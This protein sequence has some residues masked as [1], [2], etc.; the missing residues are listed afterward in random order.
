MRNHLRLASMLLLV[1]AFPCI[2]AAQISEDVVL[3]ISAE[4]D[5]LNLR[6]ST[7]VR[8][9]IEN[10][11]RKPLLLRGVSL[12][13]ER[14]T[15][16]WEGETAHLTCI[17]GDCF[18]A[19][20]PFAG[21]RTIKPADSLIVEVDLAQLHWQDLTSSIYD[22]SEPKNLHSQITQ[23]RYK[24]FIE[25]H[26]AAKNSTKSDPRVETTRSNVLPVIRKFGL[27]LQ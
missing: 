8:A 25:H 18:F 17:R 19:R 12:M 2:S 5:S 24:L 4:K 26:V 10:R 23:G 16:T 14:E 11:S 22:F 6:E 3:T 21:R 27:I 7:K 13:L 1:C 15:G 20:F 9:R